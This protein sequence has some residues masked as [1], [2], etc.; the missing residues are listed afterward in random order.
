MKQRHQFVASPL[1]RDKMMSRDHQLT[2][3]LCLCSS[4]VVSITL[5]GE[6]VMKTKFEP[7]PKMSTYLLAI[8]VSHYA[9]LNA[10]QGGT[11]VT[12]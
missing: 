6:A 9:H 2:L 5:D 3:T 7:T 4:D 8:V 1:S 10:T 12:V 11:L